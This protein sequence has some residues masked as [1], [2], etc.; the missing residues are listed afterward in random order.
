MRAERRPR[1]SFVAALVAVIALAPPV[2]AEGVYG[3]LQLQYQ[4]ADDYQT[5]V[6]GGGRTIR[7]HTTREMWLRSVDLHHQSLL[8]PD[9]LLE[10][11]FRASQQSL[12]DRDDFIR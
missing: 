7:Q 4:N 9:L 11:N 2:R 10:S 12:L 3:T 6:L 5:L 1:T 8:R